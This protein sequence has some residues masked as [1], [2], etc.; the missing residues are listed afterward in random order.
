VAGVL[1]L[2]M[3][4]P[5]SHHYLSLAKKMM[6]EIT[7]TDEAKIKKYFYILRPIANLNYIQQH[8]K[9]S[10]MEYDKTLDATILPSDVATAIQA[11]KEQKATLLE[12][13]K[14]SQHT[15]LIDYSTLAQRP[16]SPCGHRGW[17]YDF[18]HQT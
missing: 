5:V 11:L 12:H 18:E 2:Q 6:A 15:F 14:I 3:Q 7:S 17:F 9:M 10:Y 4:I 1:L 8:G 16:V 13:D